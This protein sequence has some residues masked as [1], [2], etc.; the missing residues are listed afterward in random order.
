MGSNA[1]LM[2]FAAL[3]GIAVAAV[4][5]FESLRDHLWASAALA[6]LVMAGFGM[7]VMRR[8]PSAAPPEPQT[9]AMPP[10]ARDPGVIVLMDQ[11][12]V[13]LLKHTPELG[14][15]AVNR[16]ARDLFRTDDMVM[17]PPEALIVAVE[18][19]QAGAQS[20]LRLF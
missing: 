14:L 7:A 4:F 8:D 6:A 18:R 3:A 11:L 2:R 10:D 17:E 1:Y 15:Q 9:P 5:G 19:P 13:P 12:P 20:P 16:A